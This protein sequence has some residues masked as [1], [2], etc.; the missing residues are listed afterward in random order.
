MSDFE[1]AKGRYSSSKQEEELERMDVR[2]RYERRLLSLIVEEIKRTGLRD[3]SLLASRVNIEPAM[4]APNKIR[5]LHLR[6]S[7]IKKL[8]Q[9]KDKGVL[10]SLDDIKSEVDKFVSETH[11]E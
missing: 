11:R 5:D 4:D 1:W 10:G 7:W 2:H 9:I 3:A 8:K 6:E